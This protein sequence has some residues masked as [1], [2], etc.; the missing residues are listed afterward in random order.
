MSNRSNR[1]DIPKDNEAGESR[2][3]FFWIPHLHATDTDIEQKNL[4]I[5]GEFRHGEE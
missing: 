1:R 2:R 5:A 4:H 3:L